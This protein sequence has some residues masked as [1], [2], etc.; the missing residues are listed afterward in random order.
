MA[1]KKIFDGKK[2]NIEAEK[3]SFPCKIYIIKLYMYEYMK[4]MMRIVHILPSLKN[5]VIKKGGKKRKKST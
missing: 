5:A 4:Q 3:N 2:V 1:A